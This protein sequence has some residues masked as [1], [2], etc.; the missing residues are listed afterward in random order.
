MNLRGKRTSKKS[1]DMSGYIMI[2]FG[3]G[4]IFGLL[5]GNLVLGAVIGMCYGILITVFAEM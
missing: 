2:G 1:I 3:L 5:V 4:G